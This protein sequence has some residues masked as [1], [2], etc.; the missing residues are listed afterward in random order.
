MKLSAKQRGNKP[1]VVRGVIAGLIAACLAFLLYLPGW[2]DGWEAK[3]WDWRVLAMSKPSQE[4]ENVRLILLDQASL[5]W[6][7]TENG[8]FWPWP[9]EVFI[10]IVQF[11][12]RVGV[13]TLAFHAPL[14][15]S[16]DYGN[17]DDSA[18]AREM[19]KVPV[20]VPIVLNISGNGIDA[21]PDH[22]PSQSL[23][24]E[25]LD[26][27]L[28]D[29][30]LPAYTHAVF[31]V[32]AYLGSIDVLSGIRSS[33]D[34]DDVH[35][36]VSFIERFDERVIPSLGLGTY[37]AAEPNV[38]MEIAKGKLTVNEKEIPINKAGEALLNFRGPSGTHPSYSASSI[39]Q[40]ELRM[41]ADL[42]ATIENLDGFKDSYV[43]FSFS[44]PGLL[45]YQAT[46]FSAAYPTV[47]LYATMVDNLL[48]DDFISI[49]PLWVFAVLL[50][51]VTVAMGISF[52]QSSGVIRITVVCAVFLL[53]PIILCLVAY[54]LSFWFPLV[55]METGVV[56]TFVS[57]GLVNYVAQGREKRLLGNTFGRH[58]GSGAIES[59]AFNPGSLNLA[60]ERRKITV[61]YSSLEGFNRLSETL[62]P[63]AL[64]DLLNRY[65]TAMTEIIHEEGGTL[66]RYDGE[67]IIAF[68][69]AP[70]DQP[71]H[72]ARCVRAAIRCRGRLEE[73]NSELRRITDSNLEMRIGINTGEAVVGLMGSMMRSDYTAVGEAVDTAFRV[74]KMNGEFGARIL[75]SQ[76]TMFELAGAF[77][78]REIAT[79]ARPGGK[80]PLVLYEPFHPTEMDEGKRMLIKNFSEALHS[81]QS[82]KFPQAAE[83]FSTLAAMDPVA[84]VYLRKSRELMETPV[85]Q[86]GGVWNFKNMQE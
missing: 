43:L 15:E 29:S 24:I 41:Q 1:L 64:A 40:N 26:D 12:E 59:I 30:S 10:P 79:V 55:P 7:R 57:L 60:G 80:D 82:G 6:A 62:E 67:Q 28:I 56:M 22:V 49:T 25:G 83:K 35:R 74:A 58:L 21:W 63:E 66:D 71:D 76:T 34:N 81:F 54:R 33:S 8:L 77:P 65:L 20:T 51:L 78:A 3:T 32:D 53:L 16:S 2:L 38:G 23:Y 11:C 5:D 46:P 19:H 45:D 47:E 13:K 61:F 44:A 75:V 73:L 31:P 14:T 37:L 84:D 72:A 4:T 18:L 70:L 17:E 68:W 69:N 48:A 27:W 86:W 9:R 50:L 39:I 42:K 52:L 36:R 85:E